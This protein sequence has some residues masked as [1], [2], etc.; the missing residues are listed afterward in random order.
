MASII[1]SV[2]GITRIVGAVCDQDRG[3]IVVGRVEPN[4]PPIL[5]ADLA[6]AL[7]GVRTGWPLVSIRSHG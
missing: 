7:R 3:F 1:D 5:L 2:G 6:T 4:A